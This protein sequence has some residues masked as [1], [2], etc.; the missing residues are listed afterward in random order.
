MTSPD[1][2]PSTLAG[3][4][5][6]IAGAFSEF[7]RAQDER[8]DLIETRISRPGALTG[9][10]SDASRVENKKLGSAL[11]QAMRGNDAEL[12]SMQSG[13]DDM[14][15]FL[16][17]PQLEN[18]ILSIR[19]AISPLSTVA[20]TIPVDAGSAVEL[21]IVRGNLSGSWVAEQ[22]ARPE[23][24][25]LPVQMARIELSEC[26]AMPSVTQ[27]LLDDANYDVGTLIID[28]IGHGLALVEDI[29]LHSGDGIGK[30]R[31]FLTYTTAATGD[32]TRTWGTLE[33]INTGA[34]GA[35]HT[36]GAD[37]LFDT[38]ERLHTRYRAGARWMMGRGTY[39]AVRKL[40]AVTDGQYL[41]QP[42]VA[43]GPP[44]TL[45]GFEVV[46]SEQMPVHTTT[47][48]LAIAFGDF[49]QAITIVRRPGVKLIMDPYTSKG[50]MSYYAYVRVGAGVLDFNA[51]KLVRFSA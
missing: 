35:F 45:L 3:T 49:A 12:K 44:N 18:R 27:R 11:R 48:A 10:P 4:I 9:S 36:T 34:N 50:Q 30:P 51:L 22:A 20:R 41:L 13:Q 42:S 26:Y 43:N 23:T 32:A 46:I 31:G 40:K 17:V 6:E 19:E 15:G 7:K 47:G 1:V 21:P 8:L 24:A 14:G 2:S 25:T 38:V 16:V 37:V 28:Q 39:A 29:A 33:H 5:D